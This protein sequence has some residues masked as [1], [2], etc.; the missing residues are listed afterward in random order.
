MIKQKKTPKIVQ[1]KLAEENNSRGDTRNGDLLIRAHM[2]ATH[3]HKKNLVQKCTGC[4]C[5]LCLC[6]FICALIILI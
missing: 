4:M 6:E 3:I 5:C 2:E 1:K